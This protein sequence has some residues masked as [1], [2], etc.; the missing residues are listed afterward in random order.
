VS[1]LASQLGAGFEAVA[2]GRWID[3]D[4]AFAEVLQ[5]AEVPAALMGLAS[6]KYWLGDLGGMI[7]A[8]E[9]AYVAALANSDPMLA[10][11]AALSLV[12]YE[13]QF[14]GNIAG[15]RGWLARARQLAEDHSLDLR[16]PLAGA[17][18]FVTEDPVESE[19]LA[20]EALAIGQEARD[21]DLEL[22]ALTAVGSALVQQGRIEEGMAALDQAMARAIAG[23]CGQ[24]LTV[25]HIGCMTLLV[26]ASYFDIERATSWLRAMEAFIGRYGC[27]FLD[28]ECRTHY[29]RV[30][31]ENGD[32]TAADPL[33][34]HARSMSAGSTPAAHA[35]AS[36]TL[37]ELR[38]AQG[39]LD[40]AAELLAGIEGRD[41]AV[42][43]VVALHLA[44]AEP[45][46]A[47]MPWAAIALT[48]PR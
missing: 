47:S 7:D 24:P 28:A 36:G 41:E 34:A 12:G 3:A 18:S 45:A 16:G 23:E 15:A 35:L 21:P 27:P 26:C 5:M 32:W 8:L 25:A 6:V 10:A 29:G 22:A 1:D 30:L 20:R 38:L 39:R 2:A 33:L 43:A 19:T 9:R 42:V 37:A 4:S 46:G 11:G 17:T 48:L 14:L 13:K 44:R 40:D 31:F